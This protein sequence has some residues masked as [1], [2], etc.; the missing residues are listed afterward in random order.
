MVPRYK[1]TWTTFPR[2]MEYTH[3]VCHACNIHRYSTQFMCM[4]THMYFWHCY[5]RAPFFEG[6]KF[7]EWSKKGSLWKLFSQTT[8]AELFTIHVNL[9]TME[10]LLIFGETNFVE[11]PK[12]HKIHKLYGPQKSTLRYLMHVLPVAITH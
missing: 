5:H 9:H 1:F 4:D 7:C 11:V 10:Y 2:S 6:Y 12:I 3:L 8:L